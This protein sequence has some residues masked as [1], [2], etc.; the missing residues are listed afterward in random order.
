MPASKAIH[1]PGTV[2]RI[3]AVMVYNI[4][5]TAFLQYY[6]SQRFH[7]NDEIQQDGVILDIV[8]VILQ[9]LNGVFD[10]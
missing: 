5:S 10:Q 9:L 3:N 6:D 4:W 7:E 1:S 8:E 2:R